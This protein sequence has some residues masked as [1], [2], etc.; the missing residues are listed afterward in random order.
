MPDDAPA[1]AAEA[2]AATETRLGPA[3]ARL[4]RPAVRALDAGSDG[5]F[6]AGRLVNDLLSEREEWGLDVAVLRLPSA[7]GDEGREQAIARL[8]ALVRPR[9]QIHE[10]PPGLDEHWRQTLV[11]ARQR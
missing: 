2:W 4:R 10:L 1:R 8:A 11:P 9:I 7:L 3:A 6:D 5:A